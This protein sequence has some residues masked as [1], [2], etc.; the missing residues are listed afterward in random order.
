MYW[1]SLRKTSFLVHVQ[2]KYTTDTL[3]AENIRLR[4]DDDAQMVDLSVDL[5]KSLRSRSKGISTY[6]DAKALSEHLP[7]GFKSLSVDDHGIIERINQVL[8]HIEFDVPM[9]WRMHVALKGDYWFNVSPQYRKHHAYESLTFR[10]Q[11]AIADP[12][13]L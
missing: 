6:I 8:R 1:E 10:V 13:F 12:P 3:H 4:V 11:S 2:R 9:V 7:D 5:N